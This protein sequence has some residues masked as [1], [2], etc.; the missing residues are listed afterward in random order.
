MFE[1]EMT[2]SQLEQVQEYLGSIARQRAE[3]QTLKEEIDRYQNVKAG[4]D[5]LAPLANGIFIRAKAVEDRT[6]LVNAGAGA[7]VPKSAS[8]VKTMLDKQLAELEE[9]DLQLHEQFD[10]LLERL[11]QIQKEFEAGAAQR[12]GA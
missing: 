2:N 8:E 10:R 9:Y 1:A 7:V 5:I 11:A 4:D 3:I 12:K 6:F